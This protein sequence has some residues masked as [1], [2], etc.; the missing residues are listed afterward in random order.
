[1]VKNKKA[2]YVIESDEEEFALRTMH[3]FEDCTVLEFED[4]GIARLI[5]GWTFDSVDVKD[6]FMLLRVWF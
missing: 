5:N 3:Y 4:F 2:G 6:I 1:M